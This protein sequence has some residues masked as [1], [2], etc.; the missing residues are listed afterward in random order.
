MRQF[1]IRARWHWHHD[2]HFIHFVHVAVEQRGESA[3]TALLTSKVMLASFFS[4]AVTRARSPL[5]LRSAGRTSTETL[6]LV[7]QAG[8]QLVELARLARNDDQV[9][10]AS[11]Q[12]V[13]INGTHPED[14]R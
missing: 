1:R 13:G 11:R 7:R 14:A 10:T 3:D 5:S 2:Q 12:A 6:G 8:R 4:V 9:V